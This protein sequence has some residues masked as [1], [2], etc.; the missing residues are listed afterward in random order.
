MTFIGNIWELME[1]LVWEPTKQNTNDKITCFQINVIK[2]RR[3]Y[4][5]K[6][7]EK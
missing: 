2:H 6:E 5:L 7:K 3:S 4:V 1:R